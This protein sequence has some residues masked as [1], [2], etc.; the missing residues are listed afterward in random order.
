M[1]D[2]VVESAPF[3]A[4]ARVMSG[5][6][7]ILFALSAVET[8]QLLRVRLAGVGAV[9]DYMFGCGREGFAGWT[10][11]LHDRGVSNK[12]ASFWGWLW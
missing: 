9:S 3:L 4:E 11:S 2:A 5:L 6:R 1:I 8:G 10:V 7:E 12:K